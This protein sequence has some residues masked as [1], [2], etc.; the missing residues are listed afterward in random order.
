VFLHALAKVPSAGK[1]ILLLEDS[2]EERVNERVKE[3]THDNDVYLWWQK[4]YGA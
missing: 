4:F 1:L 3:H 2:A